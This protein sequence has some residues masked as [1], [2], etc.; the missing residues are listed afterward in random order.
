MSLTDE[1]P[2]ATSPVTDHVD[3]LVVG[4]GISGIGAAFRA[5]VRNRTAIRVRSAVAPRTRGSALSSTACASARSA[6]SA[7]AS[8]TR[9]APG[10]R[11]SGIA[12]NSGRPAGPGLAL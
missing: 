12:G 7:F 9:G 2:T 4:A 10:P 8:G 11:P 1:A 5:A 3:V 6:L